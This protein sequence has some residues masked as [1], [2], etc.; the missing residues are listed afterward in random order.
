[1]MSLGAEPD[2]PAIGQYYLCLDD[3]IH[4]HTVLSTQETESARHELT[5]SY[6]KSRCRTMERSIGRCSG[7]LVECLRIHTCTESDY[8]KRGCVRVGI[9]YELSS[10][11]QWVGECRLVLGSRG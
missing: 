7:S 9:E 2:N 4:C 6:R 5:G 1:L 11:D 8:C 3:T 10:R